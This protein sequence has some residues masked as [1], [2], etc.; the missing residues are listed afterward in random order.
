[1]RSKLYWTIFNNQT[2]L[3]SKPRSGSL[4]DL[5]KD[6]EP[7]G[8]EKVGKKITFAT[9]KNPKGKK[10]SNIK[11]LHGIILDFDEA[12]TEEMEDLLHE[13]RLPFF[14]IAHNSFRDD[15]E[16]V[17]KFRLLIPL[18][19]IIEALDYEILWDFLSSYIGKP[20]A[21][22]QARPASTLFNTR[23]TSSKM[24]WVRVSKCE[25]LLDPLNLP[26]GVFLPYLVEDYKEKKRKEA[27]Q[28]AV[29]REKIRSQL[30]AE[31][32]RDAKEKYAK[33]ALNRACDEIAQLKPGNR[34]HL[35]NKEA[36]KI[37]TLVAA[38]VLR[39]EDAEISLISAAI[40]S[41]HDE[42]ASA[43]TVQSGLRAGNKPEKA[44]DLST[45]GIKKIGSKFSLPPETVE[46]IPEP[47]ENLLTEPSQEIEKEEP[48][49]EEVVPDPPQEM[50]EEEVFEYFGSREAY[51][52]LRED[53]VYWIHFPKNSKSA[54]ETKICSWLKVTAETR[55]IY[56]RNWGRLL[57]FT[58]RDGKLHKWAMPME[59]MANDGT[60]YRRILL[61]L[62]LVISGENTARSKLNKYIMDATPGK[63]CVCTQKTGWFQEK[64]VLP[65]RVIGQSDEDVNQV[66]F[67]SMNPSSVFNESGTLQEWK[68]NV[69]S[70]CVGNS[71]LVLSVCIGLASALL[72]VMKM[73]SGGFHFR[74]G[75][76]T[77]KSTALRVA[78]S[79]FG[80]PYYIRQWRATDNAL[81][82]IAAQQNDAL[83]IL[84]EIGQ[85]SPALAGNIA[86]MLANGCSKARATKYGG[87]TR[88]QLNWRLFFLSSGEIGLSEHMNSQNIKAQAGMELRLLEIPADAGAGLGMFENLH[89]CDSGAEFADTLKTQADKYYG[90]LFPAWLEKLVENYS[91]L[92]KTVFESKKAFSKFVEIEERTGQVERTLDRFALA[93]VA[94]ELATQWGLTGWEPMEATKAAARCFQDWMDFRGTTGNLEEMQVIEKT[95]MFFQLHGASRFQSWGL[96]E[97]ETIIN[98][99]GFRRI[100]H[101]NETEFYVFPEVFKNEICKGFSSRFAAKVL[102]DKGML[103]SNTNAATSS[104]K[105]P[106]S[107]K[108]SRCYH[109]NIGAITEDEHDR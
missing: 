8:E 26:G 82:G 42:E 51:F 17:R 87:S 80:T 31:P 66:L 75:S 57:E 86:Y 76:S 95:R 101:E 84:D 69:G 7:F 58:D 39:F 70:L 59:H 68:K 94:G 24:N 74:G 53:G 18:V 71:R 93:A 28:R 67:Q 12:S 109:F 43:A 77:G 83:L 64:F 96:T 54:Q 50:E 89:H 29:E 85:V 79:V 81:E 48:E 37:G 35:I 91:T 19:Q 25:N 100:T 5:L 40:K 55:D 103:N 41:G 3:Y 46:E 33:D 34:N 99:A 13:D 1:M 23:R 102:M 36:F 15:P 78:A 10:K 61:N 45:I 107:K 30:D 106:G 6:L 38:G 56:S 21:D 22:R 52:E 32:S 49:E 73:D 20:R 90:C 11:H 65:E 2:D 104:I 16:K 97:G 60:E 44:R 108:T 62:G 14:W 4:D 105:L 63:K 72:D 98:R 27:E 47:P 88:E 92:Y 9:F